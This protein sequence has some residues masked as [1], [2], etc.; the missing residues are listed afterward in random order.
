MKESNGTLNSFIDRFKQF[1]TNTK[2]VITGGVAI[3]VIAIGAGFLYQGNDSKSV[4]FS[5]LSAA[6]ASQV[7]AKLDELKTNYSIKESSD[8]TITVYV[9]EKDAAVARMEVSA[10]FEPSSGVVGYEI[11]DSTSFGE[12]QADREQ[13][14]IRALEGE[15]TKT[16]QSLPF[17]NSARVHINVAKDSFLSTNKEESTASITLQLANNQQINKNQ[18]LGIIKMVSNAVHNLEPRNVEVLDENANLLSQGLFGDDNSYNNSDEQVKVEKEK[19]D[20]I[21]SKIQRLLDKVVGTGNSVVEVDLDLNFDKKE[22]AEQ[23]LGDKVPISE[24][25][26]N[27]ETVLNGNKDELPGVDSNAE[28]EDYMANS[29]TTDGS[30][31]EV[32]TETQTNYEVSTRNEKTVV[33]TGVINKMTVSVVVNEPAIA[34]ESGN[35]N[36]QL[37]DELLSNIKTAAGFNL[38]RED[39]VSLTVAKFNNDAE[40]QQNQLLQQEQKNNLISKGSQIIVVIAALATLIFLIKKATDSFKNVETQSEGEEL[41]IDPLNLGSVEVDAI[42]SQEDDLMIEERIAK[43]IDTNAEDA[44]KAI[45]FMLSADEQHK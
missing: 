41:R 29:V 40:E 14:K 10:T 42:T 17:I 23:I 34:D 16:L 28:Q 2:I 6:D 35:V 5:S 13:K 21:K 9:N 24:K 1:N 27:K 19:E 32:Y 7:T 33:A 22:I 45:R 4:L 3:C 38:E 20:S 37:K 18:T 26:I 12:T 25:E 36:Q 11:L 15:I 39:E 8:G 30:S 44:V 43:T 31:K